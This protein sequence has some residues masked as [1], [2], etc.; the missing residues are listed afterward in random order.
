MNVIKVKEE[1]HTVR[2]GEIV[3]HWKTDLHLFMSATTIKNRI[4]AG[5]YL[6]YC[7]RTTANVEYL[8]YFISV[9]DNMKIR[10][11]LY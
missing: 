5:V 3:I 9:S 11:S 10:L 6:L 4:I 7:Y 8:S 1:Y 2:Q